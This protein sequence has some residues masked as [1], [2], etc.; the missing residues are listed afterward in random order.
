MKHSKGFGDFISKRSE[1]F[2][3]FFQDQE[4]NLELF[5][6]PAYLVH[7]AQVYIEDA[8]SGETQSSAFIA[9]QQLTKAYEM[10][11]VHGFYALYFLGL[12]KV[13]RSQ[14]NFKKN[15]KHSKFNDQ[16]QTAAIIDLDE[17]I[18]LCEEH[19]AYLNGMKA[20]TVFKPSSELSMQFASVLE[21]LNSFRYSANNAKETIKFCMKNNDDKGIEG[22]AGFSKFS[23]L[24]DA[25]KN[26]IISKKEAEAKEKE[27]AEEEVKKRG[28]RIQTRQSSRQQK[29]GLNFNT[30][31]IGR[32]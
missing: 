32:N 23:D 25:Y 3:A 24:E 14:C 5:D 13:L 8:I 22:V 27:I 16:M 17:A 19:I 20:A 26:F 31:L 6:N 10:D 15:N 18:A 21:L 11:P 4:K 28:E 9:Q 29:V 2:E 30:I 12:A 1:L 7:I